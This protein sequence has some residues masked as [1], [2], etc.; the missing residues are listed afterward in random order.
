MN[1]Q[2][3]L[4]TNKIAFIHIITIGW[5]WMYIDADE[6]ILPMYINIDVYR[7]CNGPAGHWDWYYTDI[8]ITIGIYDTKSP[9][10]RD[11]LQ[12]LPALSA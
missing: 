11:G 12:Y 9:N 10:A 6:I 8:E 1:L 2:R 7:C 3:E 5:Y 4:D